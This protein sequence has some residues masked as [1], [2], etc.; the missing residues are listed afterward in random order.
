M[1]T[2]PRTL[3]RLAAALAVS[4]LA[5]AGCQ[6]VDDAAF[7]QR[8]RGYL[9]A[10]PE[11]IREAANQLAAK[12]KIAARKATA[13]AM[14]KYR[15]QLERDPRDFVANPDGKITVVEFFDYR[16]GYC[17]LV[18]PEV[19][20]L[21]GENPDIRFVFKE[22]PIFGEVSDTAAKMALTPEGKSKGLA[23][24]GLWMNDKALTEPALDRHLASAGLSPAAVRMAAA[25][26]AIGRQI[27]DTRALAGA[28]KID[29]TP[30]FIVG[31]TLIPGADLPA[32]RAAITQARAGNLKTLS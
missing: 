7:G 17:K 3:A 22:F 5:L 16:C 32:L 8:V 9:M 30:A 24:Y 28:L 4:S 25:D 19:V 20:K 15:A 21:I 2:A 18:A 10:H 13:E 23:L 1:K 29:G 14:N 11:V 31:D 27:L 26:P 12:D 6:K